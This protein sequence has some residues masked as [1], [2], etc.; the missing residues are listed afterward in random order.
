MS[1]LELHRAQQGTTC[2]ILTL[3]LA[4]SDKGPGPMLP[5]LLAVQCSYREQLRSRTGRK[6]EP[7]QQHFTHYT[8]LP[9]S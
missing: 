5:V 4:R 6:S 7:G 1:V 8:A 9:R 3:A 2:F